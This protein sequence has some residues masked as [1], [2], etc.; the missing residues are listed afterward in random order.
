MS[1]S[2]P[3]TRSLQPYQLEQVGVGSL[4]QEATSP[5]KLEHLGIRD[6]WRCLIAPLKSGFL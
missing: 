4:T 1:E 6:V 3:G 5:V 2:V